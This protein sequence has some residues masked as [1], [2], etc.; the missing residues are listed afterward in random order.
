M[1][2]I[3]E[4]FHKFPGLPR[5]P[6]RAENCNV[7]VIPRRV[8]RPRVRIGHRERHDTEFYVGGELLHL[9]NL[10]GSGEVRC[11]FLEVERIPSLEKCSREKAAS[12][13]FL[14]KGE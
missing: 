13:A 14:E 5:M 3:D 8:H 11:L 9:R 2:G 7:L 12:V 6:G 4:K 10:P 1:P